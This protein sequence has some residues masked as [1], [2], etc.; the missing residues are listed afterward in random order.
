MSKPKVPKF[1]APPVAAPEAV[2]ENAP[3]AA[4]GEQRNIR[5]QQGYQK[6]ILTGSLKPNT[7]KKQVL[8]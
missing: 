4:E 2:V 5:R 8:G 7:G 6:Q 1:K 3:Q